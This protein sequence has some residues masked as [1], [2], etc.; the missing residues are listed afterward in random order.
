MEKTID[1]K[2]RKILFELEQ[3]SRQ[4]LNNIAKKVGLKKETIF[5]RI[6]NLEKQGIIIKYITEINIYKLGYQFYP[7]LFK[8]K[9][10]TP[11]TEEKIYSFLQ[12]NKHIGWLTKCEGAWDINLT[13]VAKG[14]QELKI[15]LESFLSKFGK[16]IADKQIFI[17]TELNYFR[18]DFWLNKKTQT[19]TTINTTDIIKLKPN[20]LKLIKILSNEARTPLV[21]IGEIF[22]TDPKN[23]A[24][25]IKNLK[26]TN[27]IQGS[28]IFINFS[29]IGHKFYKTFFSL[30]NTSPENMKKLINYLEKT[31]NIIWATKLI[32]N[33]DLSIEMEVKDNEEFRKTIA[34]IKLNF[35]NIINKHESLLIFEE[36]ALNYFP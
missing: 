22:K 34:N 17:T 27:I 6:K 8:L 12:N 35:S 2:N 9:D 5:H 29:K 11:I 18:R 13:I 33:Y 1:L 7:I 15:F 20:D 3:D 16:Y 4:S 30:K 36:K 25:K 28:R 31:K 14:N 24:Y 23:I 32:G 10:T 26:K 21:K 19:T